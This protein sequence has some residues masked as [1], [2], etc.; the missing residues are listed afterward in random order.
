M[1]RGFRSSTELMPDFLTAFDVEDGR[2]VCPRRTQTVTA[3]QA[4]FMMNNQM[5][6]EISTSYA[7]RLTE[8]CTS[9]SAADLI[10]LSFRTALGRPPS[11]A[12]LVKAYQYVGAISVTSTDDLLSG[13][14]QRVDVYNRDRT[15]GLA[16]L[17]LNLDEF[18]YLR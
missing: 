3:P 6:D 17:L 15:K 10:T 2:A 18:I 12:E 16:W 7:K 8:L 4:L 5:V 9:K 11:E 1:Q 14:R 13:S